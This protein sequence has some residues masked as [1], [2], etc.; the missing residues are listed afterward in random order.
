MVNPT[1]IVPAGRARQ[2][3]TINDQYQR[4]CPHQNEI[5]TWDELCKCQTYHCHGEPG[6]LYNLLQSK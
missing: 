6:G 3:I 2:N 4:L 1:A 5:S